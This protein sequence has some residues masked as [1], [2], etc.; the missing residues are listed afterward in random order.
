MLKYPISHELSTIIDLMRISPWPA[1]ELF[2]PQ[3]PP[4]A[5]TA[6]TGSISSAQKSVLRSNTAGTLLAFSDSF[7]EMS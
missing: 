6:T 3:L 2:I 4:A 7:F 5:L 1:R